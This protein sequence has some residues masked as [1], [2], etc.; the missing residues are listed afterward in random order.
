MSSLLRH[1]DL[2]STALGSFILRDTAGVLVRDAALSGSPR[3][4]ILTPPPPNIPIQNQM[5]TEY[6]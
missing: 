2:A 5:L 4:V 1:I 6:F 3:K